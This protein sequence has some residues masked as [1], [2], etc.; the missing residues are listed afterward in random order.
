M[1]ILTIDIETYSSVD[2]INCG[3]YKY[4]EAP[5][6]EILLFAYAYDDEPVQ[7]VDLT[8]FEDLPEIV[9][10][11]LTNPAIIKAAFNAN[12]ERT[13]IA[14]HFDIP[15]D[16]LQWRCTA[17]WALTLGLPGSLE[18]A[19]KALNLEQ[20]KDDRGKNLIK[21]FSVPCKPTKVNGQRTRNHPHH[22]PEKWEEYKAYNRQD[23][24]VEREI[25]KKLERFPVPEHEWKVWA[26]DQ[27]INDT[28]IRLDKKLARQALICNEQFESKLYEEALELTGLA[29]PNSNQQLRGWLSEQG[30]ETPDG[31]GKEFMPGLIEA[32]PNMKVRRALEIKQLLGKTSVDKYEAMQRSVCADDRIRGVFQFY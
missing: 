23:V 1:P 24:V 14:K 7:V 9:M 28:G 30:L 2:L 6:F 19:A 31:L 20:K 32:A 16:P 10:S 5:D 13:C 26:L 12:F 17:A 11:D 15:C 8:A 3:V 27:R 25:R 21:Y 29:N 4:A 22:D 18:K